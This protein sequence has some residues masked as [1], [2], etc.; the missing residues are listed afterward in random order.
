MSCENCLPEELIDLE[1]H[2]ILAGPFSS[3]EECFSSNTVIPGIQVNA[4]S[5]DNTASITFDRI[6]APGSI[7]FT[8]SNSSDS[9]LILYDIDSSASFDGEISL[10][11]TSPDINPANNPILFHIVYNEQLDKI[12]YENITTQ[13]SNGIIYGKTSSLSPF[14]IM[15]DTI[16]LDIDSGGF[17]PSLVVSGCS[18]PGGPGPSV[19]PT[20]PC[21][22]NQTRGNWVVNENGVPL[23]SI[24]ATKCDCYEPHPYL[25]IDTIATAAA[26][27]AT[28]AAPACV[29]AA[30]LKNLGLPALRASVANIRGLL[31]SAQ[32]YGRQ[33]AK[34]L[35]LLLESKAT[36]TSLLDVIDDEILVIREQAIINQS[37][38][39][40][41]IRDITGEQLDDID[42]D[43]PLGWIP[44]D[45]YIELTKEVQERYDDWA[46]DLLSDVSPEEADLFR[47]WKAA[48]DESSELGQELGSKGQQKALLESEILSQDR[49]KLE[50]Q[51]KILDNDA[52]TSGAR[53]LLTEKEQE[54]ISKEDTAKSLVRQM[55]NDVAGTII[56]TGGLISA[57]NQIDIKKTCPEGFTLNTETCDCCPN[58]I[59]GKI[60]DTNS[61]DCICPD[62]L[63][64]CGDSCCESTTT[65]T[66]GEPGCGDNLRITWKDVTIN[67]DWDNLGWNGPYRACIGESVQCYTVAPYAYRLIKQSCGGWIVSLSHTLPTT[68]S[69]DKGIKGGFRVMIYQ[70]AYSNPTAIL[71]RKTWGW[72]TYVNGDGSCSDSNPMAPPNKGS[73]ALYEVGTRIINLELADASCRDILNQYIQAEPQ[74]TME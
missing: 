3:E 7:S 8:K 60:L 44:D 2:D 70:G 25:S 20:E 23:P 61:C 64:P 24:V 74:V 52:E 34:G 46:S 27:I 33:L 31:A 49:L 9:K 38:I 54:L 62:N 17:N 6:V 42:L 43:D 12:I 72:C 14:V 48:F 45:R 22:G 26:A 68:C 40:Q 5:F 19:L 21:S 30:S 53:A 51:K 36:L 63:V 28:G 32:S 16:G 58:C 47:Q 35:A 11:F 50:Q 73:I 55:L 66:T 15:T 65:T 1:K 39:T 59:N 41:L 29:A 56:A 57:I 4:S 67:T 37:K 71:Y 69:S 18:A 10:S 13:V